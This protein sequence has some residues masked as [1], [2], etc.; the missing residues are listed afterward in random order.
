MA[1]AIYLGLLIVAVSIRDT[2]SLGPLSSES[3][4]GYAIA[5]IM[6]MVYDLANLAIKSKGK[7]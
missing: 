1:T 5:L 3:M 2:S 7:K 4:R 6:F